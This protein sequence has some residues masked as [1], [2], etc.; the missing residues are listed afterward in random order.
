MSAGRRFILALGGLAL[1]TLLGTVGYTLIE[2]MSPFDAL[3]MTVIT[4]STVGFGEVKPLNQG[5]RLFTMGLIVTG[6]GTAFYLFATVTELVVEGRLREFLEKSAM[7][8][9]IHQLEG[10]VIICGFGRFGKVVAEEMIQNSLPVVVI[11]IDPAKE[12]ELN[13]LG[14]PYVLGSA[15]ED[16]I[17]EQASIRTARAIVVGTPSDAD[18]VFITL[19]ARQ[20]NP[21]VRIHARGETEAGL[22][23]L[24]LAGADQAISAYQWGA[25]RIA[26]TITRPSVVDFLEL[27]IPGRGSEIDLEEIRV[28]PQSPL[29]GKAIA[30]VEDAGTRLRIVALKRG[31]DPISIIPNP[32]TRIEA[33]DFLVVIG[34]RAS[35]K[36]LGENGGI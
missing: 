26:A 25:M 24:R 30:A 11:E 18:N 6:V 34:E 20:K 22:R 12:S 31:A 8:R 10:H 5:G 19:S 4:I 17:I 15:L 13:R 29:A 16:E 9:K 7:Y 36:R 21:A 3:Y 2:R 35:L 33:G 28:A 27:S 14:I 32:A 1:L 23:H